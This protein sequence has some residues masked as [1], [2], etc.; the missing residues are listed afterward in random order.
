[1]L[2]SLNV[3]ESETDLKFLLRSKFTHG[4]PFP[5]DPVQYRSTFWHDSL[6]VMHLIYRSKFCERKMQF[7]KEGDKTAVKAMD[8]SVKNRWSWKWPDERLEHFF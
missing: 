6:L 1:M 4:K 7:L 5:R 8:S 2:S 3:T